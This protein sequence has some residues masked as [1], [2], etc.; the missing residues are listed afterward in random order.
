MRALKERVTLSVFQVADTTIGDEAT[1]ILH[2]ITLQ[3]YG[4][5]GMSIIGIEDIYQFG[6]L[7]AL[8]INNDTLQI[9]QALVHVVIKHHERKQIVS[10]TTEVCIQNH[11][12]G[13]VLL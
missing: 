5:I 11:L 3:T 7:H 2:T 1:G 13:L 9:Y 12:D 10:R 4:D 6:I 8:T